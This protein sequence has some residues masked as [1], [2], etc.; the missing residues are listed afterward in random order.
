MPKYD[1]YTLQLAN[2]CYRKL[3]TLPYNSEVCTSDIVSEVLVESG[4]NKIPDFM[5]VHFALYDL[6]K[7]KGAYVMDNTKYAFQTVG[8]PENIPYFF[9]PKHPLGWAIFQSLLWSAASDRGNDETL[10]AKEIV[11]ITDWDYHGYEQPIP[12]KQAYIWLE[13]AYRKQCRLKVVLDAEFLKGG[14]RYGQ[15]DGCSYHFELDLDKPHYPGE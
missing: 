10:Y 6:V 8:L 4:E 12:L 14:S 13:K 11:S 15:C 3:L 5:Q 2:L 9:R 1:D 7:S